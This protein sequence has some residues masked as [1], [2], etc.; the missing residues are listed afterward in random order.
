[1]PR[2][3]GRRSPLFWFAL[4]A[5]LCGVALEYAV[6]FGPA[7]D[8]GKKVEVVIPRGATIASVAGRLQRRRAIR[9]AAAFR[10]L[11]RLKGDPAIPAGAYLVSPRQ[12]PAAILQ[13][14]TEGTGERMV[15]VTFPEGFTLEQMAE[16]VS[17]VPG[18]RAEDFQPLAAERGRS[19]TASF[20]PPDNLEGFLFPDTYDF[21]PDMPARDV[22]QAM[23][24]NFD[25]KVAGP[26]APD[27]RSRQAAGYSLM[28][29]VTIASLIEREAKVPGDRDIIAGVIYN[30]LER[31]IP[32][33]IDATV[34]YVI[35]HRER[36]LYRDLKVDSPYNTYQ[37][38][39][40]PPGPIC[41]PGLPA[42]RAALHPRSVPYLYYTANP[43]GAHT[44]TTTLEAHNRATAAARAGRRRR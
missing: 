15:R 12:T 34:Q 16:R 37:H 5:A 21:R 22:V 24:E 27:F 35:G 9:S 36:L 26:L 11:A 28:Q 40:L 1:M 29:V 7:S 3:R 31:G 32:L 25:Q 23:L 18:V 20:R 6:F 17:S 38:P 44:F 13:Q 39:G 41:N 14:L 43:D 42:I 33:Q 8:R 30:R 4:S 2:R 19:F 10:L